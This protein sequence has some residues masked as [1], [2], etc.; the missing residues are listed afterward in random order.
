M[1]AFL[2]VPGPVAQ[3]TQTVTNNST[4]R[5]QWDPP[6]MPNGVILYYVVRLLDVADAR[7]LNLSHVDALVER[8]VTYEHLGQ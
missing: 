7:E 4:A 2:S 8:T 3:M 6:T 1:F 5:I